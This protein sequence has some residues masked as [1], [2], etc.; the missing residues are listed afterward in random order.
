M[1]ASLARMLTRLYPRAWRGRYGAEF[2]AFLEAEQGG[3]RA[4]ANVIWSAL[5]ER[6]VP[7]RGGEMDVE[8]NS[9]VHAGDGR[10]RRPYSV[11]VRSCFW[12]APTSLPVCI[13]GLSGRFFRW[14]DTS[15]G[16]RCTRPTVGIAA[17][18]FFSRN[19]DY[20]ARLCW[21]VSGG[22]FAAHRWQLADPSLILH[23]L[24]GGTAQI[25]ASRTAVP[26]GRTDAAALSSLYGPSVM[27]LPRQTL[28]VLG[29]SRCTVFAVLAAITKVS[30]VVRLRTYLIN[31]L[32]PLAQHFRVALESRA[33]RK[34]RGASTN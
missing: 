1:N 2:A 19:C 31:R 28:F 23:A 7:T 18:S 32:Q 21:L 4:L 27:V 12:L 26:N 6:M 8:I 11:S 16:V 29:N 15:L 33:N 3:V 14:S 10:Q 5:G 13:C 9:F 20:L 34:L 25:Q 30:F 24:R 22:D 17:I